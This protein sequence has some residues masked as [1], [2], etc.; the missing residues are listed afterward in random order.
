MFV[1][2]DHVPAPLPIIH[3][4]K[5]VKMIRLSWSSTAFMHLQTQVFM[6]GCNCIKLLCTLLLLGVFC[7]VNV[8]QMHRFFV[9]CN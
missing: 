9:I 7:A 6:N 1:V 8:L 4:L 2:L 3:Q 5:V